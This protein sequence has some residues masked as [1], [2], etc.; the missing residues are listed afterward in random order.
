MRRLPRAVH[1]KCLTALVTYASERSMPAA[2]SPSSSTLPA[3]PTKGRPARSSLS[4]GCSPTN[5]ISAFSDPSPKTVCVPVF[6]RS[7]ALQSAASAL[8]S[9]RLR[10]SAP[11]SWSWAMQALYPLVL[12]ANED[13]GAERDPPHEHAQVG[14]ACVRAA[15]RGSRADRPGGVRPVD[16]D[17][18]AARPAEGQVGLMGRERENAASVVGPVAVARE[19]VRHRETSGRGGGAGP[20]HSNCH[21]ADDPVAFLEEESAS[22]EV[23][24]EAR[25]RSR[26]M[27]GP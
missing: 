13:R 9:S 20:A 25:L 10:A 17:A 7:Q 6:Q 3:G 15:R 18:V 5:T 21:P 4:P 11:K 24:H 26:H 23:E 16:R 2:S 19:L 14:I 22:R 12:S 1:L 27:D 8:S